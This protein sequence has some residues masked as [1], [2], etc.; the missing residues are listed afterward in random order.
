MKKSVVAIL[1]IGYW[2]IFLLLILLI[3]VIIA[4]PEMNKDQSLHIGKPF[5]FFSIIALVP[6]MISF[7]LYY[8]VVFKKYFLTKKIL[9]LILVGLAIAGLAGFI[10]TCNILFVGYLASESA[11]TI[12]IASLIA[13][14]GVTSV[15]AL[16]NG[17][18]GLVMRGFIVSY[19][20]IKLK[21]DLSQKNHEIELDLIRSQ[22]NPHFLF[23]TINNID[24]LIQKDP[25]KASA[26]L[27][28]LSDIMRFMLYETKTEKIALTKELA[29]IEKYI[30]LQK[31]RTANQD[32]INYEVKGNP[33]NILIEPML[34][35]PFIENAFKHVGNKKAENAIRVH[36][37]I[38][39]KSITFECENNYA[40][41]LQLKPEQGGLG[42][43]L[44]K[45]RLQLLYPDKHNLDINDQNEIY[46]VKLTLN[47]NGN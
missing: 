34:F 37:I 35:I 9:Q 18:I 40:T 17:I 15:G 39:E 10:G 19:N 47:Y 22:I 29:Y 21:E 42:N 2:I 45:K 12:N 28:Q 36:L 46:K 8:T 27:N 26:Y 38:A 3:V 25:I 14:T 44:I 6:G 5:I 4:L 11:G 32:Y 24:V 43:E 30:E 31:I 13:I 1:H 7:Y 16:L 23:N 33:S 20:D 41:A